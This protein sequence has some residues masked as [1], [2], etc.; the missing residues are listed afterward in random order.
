[1]KLGPHAINQ[2]KIPGL[3]VAVLWVR[4][5]VSNRILQKIRC[6]YKIHFSLKDI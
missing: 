1:M 6:F 2:E 4:W 3:G 5:D